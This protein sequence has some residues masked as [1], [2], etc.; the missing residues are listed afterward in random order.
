MQFW[1]RKWSKLRE[2]WGKIF[3]DKT[4]LGGT[5]SGQKVGTV[6]GWGTGKIFATWGTPVP[7]EKT[8]DNF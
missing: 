4:Q 2:K 3:G 8:M 7:Q 6:V 1:A 5:G